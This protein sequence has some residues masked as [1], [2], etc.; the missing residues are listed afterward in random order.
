MRYGTSELMKLMKKAIIRYD[1]IAGESG[2]MVGLSGGKDSIT[3]LFMLKNFLTVS[4]YKYPLAAGHIGLGFEG[5]DIS[6]LSDF[7]RSIDVPFFYEKTD[8]GRIVFD[9]RKEEHPCSLCANLRRGALNSLA[10]NNG[11]N[12]VALGHHQD[13]VVETM[14]L[15]T[16]FEGNIASFNPVTY[17]N[18]KELT[19]IRPFIYAPEAL[20]TYNARKNELPV[21][22]NPCPANGKT[23]RQEIKEILAQINEFA[24][25][26]KDRAIG[27][28]EK[29]Y[30]SHW[31]GKTNNKKWED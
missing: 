29:L 3:L 25:R 17:L 18:R 26:A 21:I 8:I 11:Y 30:D 15:K 1:M 14:L 2:I 19:V 23:K 9:I 13:D 4:K 16:F 20:I 6:P 10:K 12:K 28:L 27:G 24:P 5:E 22:V 7:C 31:D